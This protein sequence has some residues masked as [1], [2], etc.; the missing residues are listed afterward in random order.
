M[1]RLKAWVNLRQIVP[2]FERYV[3]FFLNRPEEKI[4]K[5]AGRAKKRT[6]EV[7]RYICH[8]AKPNLAKAGRGGY[9]FFPTIHPGFRVGGNG[10][11]G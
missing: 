2:N 1:D 3:K 6:D 4:R 8:W 9:L 5:Q 11:I 7:L 10:K